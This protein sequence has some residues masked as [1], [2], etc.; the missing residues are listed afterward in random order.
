MS[1][2][3][4]AGGRVD[5]VTQLSGTLS[6]NSSWVDH[7]YT[8][9]GITTSNGV[10]QGFLRDP[11]A[12]PLLSPYHTGTGHS[13]YFHTAFAWGDGWRGGATIL[14]L[15][16]NSGAPWIQ[17]TRDGHFQYNSGS[18]GTPVW[19]DFAGSPVNVPGYSAVSDID[20]KLDLAAGG[21]HTI[22]LAYGRTAVIGPVGFTQAALTNIA[23]FTLHGD[24]WGSGD[25]WSELLCTEDVSTVGAH[26]AIPRAT[27]AGVHS[28]W[29]GTYTD[30]NE[31]QTNDTTVNQA[32]A[33]GLLQSYPMGNI[34]VPAGYV[35]PSIW[36]WLRV[37][38]DGG[39][40]SSIQA[41]CRPSTTD[42]ISASLPAVGVTF[43]GLG[44]R[45]DINPDTGVAWTQADWNAPAQMGFESGA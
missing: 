42:H 20:I 3:T 17:L 16:D 28:D 23:S 14:Q 5:S 7:A 9:A 43:A 37:K 4:F 12:A 25:V 24:G 15:L 1:K 38:N 19:T 18:S 36:Q 30:V 35:I 11:A 39:A 27:G 2:I 21:A 32:G 33:A 41:I 45:Y 34:T 26:V 10:A 29:T 22:L 44:S 40:P 31:V 6:E 8:D 13:F